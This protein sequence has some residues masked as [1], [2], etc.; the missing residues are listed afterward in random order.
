MYQMPLAGLSESTKAF[1]GLGAVSLAL[2]KRL[3]SRLRKESLIA[4]LTHLAG[5]IIGKALG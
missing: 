3:T 2:G 4:G 5:L 1:A